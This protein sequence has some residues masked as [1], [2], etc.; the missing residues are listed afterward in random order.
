MIRCGATKFGGN[1]K[2][3]ATAGYLESLGNPRIPAEFSG[4]DFIGFDRTELLINAINAC[5]YQLTARNFPVITENHLVQW[6]L[7][8]H[9]VGIGAMPIG[10][11]DAEP[12]VQRMHTTVCKMPS[13]GWALRGAFVF[14][15]GNQLLVIYKES[16]TLFATPP[17]TFPAAKGSSVEDACRTRAGSDDGRPGSGGQ[18]TKPAGN[19]G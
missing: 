15:E 6:E 8:K 3:Y 16:K 18:W 19:C 13:S 7:V 5:G 2:L 14:G 4:A 17:V 12:L 9:G 10:V 1:R 11:G